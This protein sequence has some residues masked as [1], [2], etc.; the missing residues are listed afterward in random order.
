MGKWQVNLD[1]VYDSIPDCNHPHYRGNF[2][3]RL[4]HVNTSTGLVEFG[5][6]GQLSWH[7][8]QGNTEGLADIFSDYKTI[9]SSNVINEEGTFDL[10]EEEYVVNT[11]HPDSQDYV[12]NA[13]KGTIGTEFGG[14]N[15]SDVD[16]SNIGNTFMNGMSALGDTL[17]NFPTLMG[18][19]ASFLPKEIVTLI[20]IG[21][22]L[23]IALRIWGR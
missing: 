16:L 5:P 1:D 9:E 17:K 23:V 12:I 21:F 2:Y 22:A 18:K 14:I 15:F 3:L 19:V 13:D 8:N 7:L 11:T 4:V 10:I 20:T 6:W